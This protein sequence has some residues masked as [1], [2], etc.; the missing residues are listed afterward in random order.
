MGYF[1]SYILHVT[2]IK[3]SSFRSA[4][5]QGMQHGSVIRHLPQQSQ[6]NAISKK[7][8]GDPVTAQHHDILKRL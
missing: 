1:L 3:E 8:Q 6:S 7:D 2:V 5:L 4:L